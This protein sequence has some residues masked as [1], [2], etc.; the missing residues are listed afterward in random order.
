M[1]RIHQE[2]DI[3][4]SVNEMCYIL[5]VFIAQSWPFYLED[6]GQGP[7]SL[8]VTHPHMLQ[9]ICAK[10]GKN[11]FQT[12]SLVEQTR[13]VPYFSSFDAKL[14]LNDL[15]NIGQDQKHV[16]HSHNLEIICAK[17]RKHP[18]KTGRATEQKQGSQTDGL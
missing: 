7:K 3:L 6:M 15:D 1:K 4:Q 18:S 11:P 2:L 16:T 12:A 9:I 17:Q 14:W 10:Y 13:Q 5:A 8:H